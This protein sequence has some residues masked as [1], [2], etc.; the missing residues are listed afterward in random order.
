MCAI[1][2]LEIGEGGVP[3]QPIS[4]MNFPSLYNQF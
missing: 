4:D 3:G 1:Y 2:G